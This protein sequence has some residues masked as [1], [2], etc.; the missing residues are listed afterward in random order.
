VHR[1]STD[2]RPCQYTTGRTCKPALANAVFSS[3][4]F[5]LGVATSVVSEYLGMRIATYANARTTLEARRGIDAAFP[6]VFRSGT[7]MGFLLASLGLLVLYATIKVFGL[8]Y[9]DDWEGLYES[10]ST[11]A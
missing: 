10:V 6:T 9:G 5:L 2:S 3:I 7:I 1:F 11:T 8:Y 4:A